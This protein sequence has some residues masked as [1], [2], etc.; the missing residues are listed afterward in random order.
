MTQTDRDRLMEKVETLEE[1]LQGEGALDALLCA[2][3]ERVIANGSEDLYG[4][5]SEERSQV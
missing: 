5:F 3:D 2:I 4:T 1:H